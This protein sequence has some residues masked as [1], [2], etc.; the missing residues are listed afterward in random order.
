MIGTASHPD[1]AT[2][3]KAIPGVR[4]EV[5]D[6]NDPAAVDGFASRLGATQLDVL[7]VN[8]GV[9]GPEQAA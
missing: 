1:R 2:E 4:M 7:L 6:V 5:L 9:S 8:A 3:L